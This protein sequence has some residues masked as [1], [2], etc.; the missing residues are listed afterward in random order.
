MGDVY[1][2]IRI[3]EMYLDSFQRIEGRMPCR[4]LWMIKQVIFGSSYLAV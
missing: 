1:G 4:E 2:R 3:T